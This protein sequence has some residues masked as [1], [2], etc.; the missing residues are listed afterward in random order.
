MAW[1]LAIGVAVVIS[2]FVGSTVGK[3]ILSSSA[4][5]IGMLLLSLV[6]GFAFL[7][8]LAKVCAAVI[9]ITAVVGVLI[10]IFA[11]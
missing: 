6:T 9:I 4:I 5:A 8:T 11:Y 2:F 3:I 10:V 7:I 1:I